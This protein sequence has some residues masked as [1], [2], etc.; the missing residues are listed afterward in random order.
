MTETTRTWIEGRIVD[1]DLQLTLV[2]LC[3]ATG[4]QEQQLVAWVVEGVLEPVGD[5]G[6]WQF[7]GAA[8]LRARRAQRLAQDL[9][10]EPS[11]LALVLDLID[12]IETL[13]ARIR[14]SGAF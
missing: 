3:R 10:L 5:R 4:V 11:G 1:D 8:L 12:E 2:E 7:S 13:R 14:R 6:G 9:D